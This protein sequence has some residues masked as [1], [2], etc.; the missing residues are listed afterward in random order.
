MK[1]RFLDEG[2]ASPFLSS[3]AKYWVENIMTND[4][5]QVTMHN[6]PRCQRPVN[7]C[8]GE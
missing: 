1:E 4:P 3:M 7:Q 6:K 8:C 5:K 2:L